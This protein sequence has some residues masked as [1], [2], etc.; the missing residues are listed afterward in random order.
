MWCP[1]ADSIVLPSATGSLISGTGVLKGLSVRES[2]GTAAARMTLFDGAAATGLI[3]MEVT[4]APSESIRDWFSEWGL[5]FSRGLL[6][7][8]NSGAIEGAVWLLPGERLP[9]G[10]AIGAG[11]Q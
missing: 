6:Y 9:D 10:W 1:P 2:T 7:Q 3:V 5:L 8:L 4:L 11:E